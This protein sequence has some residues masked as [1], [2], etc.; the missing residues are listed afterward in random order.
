MSSITRTLVKNDLIKNPILNLTL[1][2]FIFLSVLLMAVGGSIFYKMVGSMDQLYETAQTPH[3]LQMHVGPV[4]W[5]ALED[6]RL[7]QPDIAAMEVQEMADID[8]GQIYYEKEGHPLQNFSGQLMDHYFVAQ[9]DRLDYLLDYP[10]SEVIQLEEGEIGLPLPYAR[11]F[12]LELGDSIRLE[13]DGYQETFRISHL[14]KDS[15]MGSSLSSSLRF[16]LNEKD[17]EKLYAASDRRESII[18]FRLKDGANLSAFQSAYQSA[19]WSLPQN[20][21]AISFPLIRLANGL[22]EGLLTAMLLLI[23]VLLMIIAL[24]NIRYSLLASLEEDVRQIANLKA[25]GLKHADICHIYQA[26][27]LVLGSLACLL[28]AVIS[29]PLVHLFQRQ[30]SFQS[31]SFKQGILSFVIP[32]LASSLIFITLALSLRLVL[33]HLKDLNIVQALV[34]GRLD[35]GQKKKSQSTVPALSEWGEA[36]HGP[37]IWLGLRCHFGAWKNIGVVFFISTTMILIPLSLWKTLE[38]PDFISYMGSAP[39]DIRLQI[40]GRQEEKAQ[41]EDVQKELAADERVSQ[42]ELFKTVQG[43]VQGKERMESFKM[44]VGDYEDFK[45]EMVEG[46]FPTKEGEIALS[47][48]NADHFNWQLGSEFEWIYEGKPYHFKVVG[49]YQDISQGGMTAKMSSPLSG[50]AENYQILIRL[51]DPASLKEVMADLQASYPD[52]TVLSMA[53]LLDQTLGTLTSSL[54]L[55]SH[56]LLV[57]ALMVSGL[58]VILFLKLRLYANRGTDTILLAMGLKVDERRWHYNI[59]TLLASGSGILLAVV[60]SLTLGASLMGGLF[61]LL[62]FGMSQFRFSLS[63]AYIIGLGMLLPAGLALLLATWSSRSLEDLSLTSLGQS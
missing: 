10:S 52:W 24:I 42:F 35:S 43:Q 4:D 38:S 21:V 36:I 20:G 33:K 19:T 29:F 59:Q 45:I 22:G 15:Q 56:S 16:L 58:I 13:L 2:M 30:L 11:Q 61:S 46:H 39:M 34:D 17:F 28:A 47:Q 62:G 9:N 49:L 55:A 41:L 54:A 37:L 25:I 23:A 27:Y 44:E 60:F 3:F 57:V 32:F 1:F 8:G 63:P 50:P 40:D 14:L 6:F 12:D 7:H 48:F 26:K 31:L 51:Q 53:D 18:A 5:Q